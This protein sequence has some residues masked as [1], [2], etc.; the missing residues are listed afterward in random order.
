DAIQHHGECCTAFG[1]ENGVALLD[2]PLDIFGIMISSVEDHDLLQPPG[3]IKLASIKKPK[4]SCSQIGPLPGIDKVCVKG[5][6][7]LLHPPPITERNTR[8]GNPY[9][10]D[11][12]F[13]AAG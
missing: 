9:L 2:T 11:P 8:P 12:V 13:G 4:V 10:A 7:A 3:D 1:S 5:P 6:C